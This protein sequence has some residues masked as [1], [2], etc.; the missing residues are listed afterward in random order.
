MAL[1]SDSI[2]LFGEK[3]TAEKVE[4]DIL[5]FLRC[6]LG[7]PVRQWDMVNQIAVHCDRQ[8]ARNKRLFYLR[9]LTR[10]IRENKVVRYRKGLLRGKIRINEAYA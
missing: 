5:A 4:S 2:Q 7:N 1:L 9:H 10:L 8:E 3:V 6:H